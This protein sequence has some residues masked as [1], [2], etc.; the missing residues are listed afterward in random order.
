MDVNTIS[1]RVRQ[2]QQSRS[3]HAR[4]LL[5]P[6]RLEHLRLRTQSPLEV[7][8]WHGPEQELRILVGC[9]ALLCVSRGLPSPPPSP[10]PGS[11]LKEPDLGCACASV[12]ARAASR[13]AASSKRRPV[14]VMFIYSYRRRLKVQT[15]TL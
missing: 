4:T 8:L 14:R 6:P 7:S 15:Y 9:T 10:L 2:Q 12:A 1:P 11:T 13:K 5:R 3:P